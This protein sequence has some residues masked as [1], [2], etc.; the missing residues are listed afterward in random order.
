MRGAVTFSD[1]SVIEGARGSNVSNRKG[2][3]RCV[4]YRAEIVGSEFGDFSSVSRISSSIVDWQDDRTSELIE[5]CD[6]EG[7]KRTYYVISDL[8]VY[9][10]GAAQRLRAH[11]HSLI[12]HNNSVGTSRSKM[13]DR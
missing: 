10:L 8:S 2:T 4:L 13:C 11:P 9:Q 3:S 12:G 1:S 7:T 5:A 6:C